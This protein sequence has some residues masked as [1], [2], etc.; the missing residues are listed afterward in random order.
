MLLAPVGDKGRTMG[1]LPLV[2][3]GSRLLL[4]LGGVIG[5]VIG[6]AFGLSVH[7][8]NHGPSADEIKAAQ[9]AITARFK[10]ARPDL[11]IE[12]IV[13][14]QMPGF[15]EIALPGGTVLHAT[16]DGRYVFEGDLY[17][18]TAAGIVNLA[19][20]R[21]SQKRKEL[22]AD[23]DMSNGWTF[24]ATGTRKATISVFTDVD[25]GYCRK[26]HLEVPEL[27]AMGIEVRYLAYPR[28]GIESESYDKIVSAWCAKD[29]NDALTRLKAGQTIPTKSCANNPVEAQYVLGQR[30][31]ISGTPAIFLEDG[32]LLPGYMPAKD[33]AKSIGL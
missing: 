19:E 20:I 12:S 17:E 16:A 22:L 13:P 29:K 33:L 14:A 27:N 5:V 18:V 24:A 4:S 26:L 25:C 28:A 2:K 6:A 31:G 15:Y 11:P 10:T 23:T 30:L 21:R 8:D 32:R 9:T 7:A 3:R 1:N